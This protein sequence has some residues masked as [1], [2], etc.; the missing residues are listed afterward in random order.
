MMMKGVD[1]MEAKSELLVRERALVTPG[2]VIARGMEY[3][4]GPGTYRENGE[5]KSKVLGL[6]RLKERLVTVVSLSGVYVPK[7]GDGI[8]GKIS[9]MSATFWIVD[10]NSPYDALL[11]ISEAVPEFVEHGTDI[12]IYYDIGD[13][14]YVKVLSVSRTKNVSLTMNDYRAKKLLGGRLLT[15]T[16][17][18][19]PRVIGR[20]GSMIE[21]IKKYTGCLITVGQ[22]G[23]IWV[24]GPN[25]D[26]AARTVHLI[27][28]EAHIE[29]LTERVTEFLE[30]E[31]KGKPAAQQLQEGD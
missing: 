3:L 11:N 1:C 12:S 10:L 8:I 23:V 5:L 31:T 7:P 18:K 26:L 13:V 28:R 19:V 14:I 15:V 24:K 30:N 17:T 29:G 16:A 6:V 4:P 20:E 22:N 2:D 25:E 9:D 27:E 21:L